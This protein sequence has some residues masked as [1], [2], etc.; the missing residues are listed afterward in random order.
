MSSSWRSRAKSS[1]TAGV[2]AVSYTHL[3]GL[4]RGVGLGD[5]AADGQHEGQRLF[6]RGHAVGPGRVHDDHAAHG[7]RFDVNVVD[8]HAG[9]ADDA[10]LLARGQHVGRDLRAAADDQRVILRDDFEQLLLAHTGL[11]VDVHV[12]MLFQALQGGRAEFVGDEDFVH[13][14]SLRETADYADFKNS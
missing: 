10:Q 1:D 11:H 4:Q 12:V 13:G 3:A 2:A 9:A 7:G 6:G 14:I 8:T 5:V